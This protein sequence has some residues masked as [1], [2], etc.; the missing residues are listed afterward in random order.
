MPPLPARPVNQRR[1]LRHAVIPDH[2]GARCPLDARL[3]VCSVREVVVQK[4]EER[5][6]LFFLEADDVASD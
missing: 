2:N 6:G 1:V 4:L 3:E 5:V